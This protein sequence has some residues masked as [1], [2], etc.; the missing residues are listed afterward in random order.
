MP[1]KLY[2]CGRPGMSA[3]AHDY[4]K[5]NVKRK[6]YRD[7]KLRPIKQSIFIFFPF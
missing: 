5:K 4:I 3:M 6:E 1:R 7:E 2:L